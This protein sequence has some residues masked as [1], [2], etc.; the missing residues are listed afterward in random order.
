MSAIEF[1]FDFSSGYAYFA[2]QSID[3]IGDRTGR[4]V[5]WRPY[6]LGAAFKITGARGLSSTPLKG[7][8]ARK[9]WARLSRKMGVP[10][11]IPEG[12]PITALPA[13]RAYYWIEEQF[14]DK[15]HEFA[16]CAFRAYY[17]DG[18]DMTEPRNVAKVAA[19]LGVPEDALCD[20]IASTAIKERVKNASAEA[21]EKGVFGSPFFIVDGEPFWGWD[22]MPM[23]EEW[24]TRGGW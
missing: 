1:W 20:G 21:L 10:F 5:L 3:D 8:Y 15:A 13:S 18:V 6:M 22:R 7:D 11:S 14:P 9:D 24:L 17:V 2:A 4:D 23:L 12:H 16:R 19:S